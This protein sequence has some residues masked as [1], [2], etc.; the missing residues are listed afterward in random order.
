MKNLYDERNRLEQED[1]EPLHTLR[2]TPEPETA[3]NCNSAGVL[4]VAGES[5]VTQE[6]EDR[7]VEPLGEMGF[8]VVAIDLVKDRSK[9]DPALAISDI[10]SGLLYLKEMAGGKLGVIGLDAAAGLAMEAA[11]QLPQIDCVI[12][13]G[14]PGPRKGARLDRVRCSTLF[15]RGTKTSPLT[16]EVADAIRTRME[17]AKQTLM[18]QDYDASDGFLAKPGADE[19]EA[20]TDAYAHLTSFLSQNLI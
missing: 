7:L 10:S 3:V 20:A 4:V 15:L 14:G 19:H 9:F 18:V 1:G 17:P 11:T 8:F 6:I 12:A 5:G 16:D 2:V 13:S